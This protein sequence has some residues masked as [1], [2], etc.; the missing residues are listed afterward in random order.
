[1]SIDSWNA[2]LARLTR[3]TGLSIEEVYEKTPYET[4]EY[5]EKKNRTPFSYVSEYPTI[6]R[7]NI[8][9]DCL[10]TREEINNDVDTILR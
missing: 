7:G 6:G 3:K 1:M 9:R 8:L 2:F 4:R 10:I 5:F